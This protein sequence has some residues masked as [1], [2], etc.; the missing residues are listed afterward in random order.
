MHPSCWRCGTA[1][2][3]WYHYKYG[4]MYLCIDCLKKIEDNLPNFAPL[5]KRTRFYN[6]LGD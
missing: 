3:E 5:L 4:K 1:D 6:V 2:G